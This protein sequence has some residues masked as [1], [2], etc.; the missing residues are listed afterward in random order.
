[1]YIYHTHAG[2]YTYTC[3]YTQLLLT[4]KSSTTCLEGGSALLQRVAVWRSVLQGI[5]VP[6]IYLSASACLGGGVEWLQCVA[7]CCSVLQCVAVCCSVLQC[8]AVCCSV[9]QCVAVCCSVLQC[10]AVPY[11]FVSASIHTILVCPT[12]TCDMTS[13]CVTLSLQMAKMHRNP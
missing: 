1:M 12:H 11:I 2:T 10:V 4:R 13:S 5:A 8:A 6:C 7:V 3:T 9:L